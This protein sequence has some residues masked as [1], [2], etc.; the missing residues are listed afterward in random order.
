MKVSPSSQS[1]FLVSSQVQQ[2]RQQPSYQLA[3]STNYASH[4]GYSSQAG[5]QQHLY[6]QLNG[7]TQHIYDSTGDLHRMNMM[8]LITQHQTGQQ[9]A[10]DGLNRSLSSLQQQQQHARQLNHLQDLHARQPMTMKS[11]VLS[12]GFKS[13]NSNQDDAN[14]AGQLLTLD[15]QAALK[16]QQQFLCHQQQQQQQ[17]EADGPLVAF[18]SNS[19]PPTTFGPSNSSMALQQQQQQL[20]LSSAAQQQ[21]QQHQHHTERQLFNQQ[22]QHFYQDS[23]NSN[24]INCVGALDATSGQS[25]PAP[26]H[27][28]HQYYALHDNM[29]NRQQPQ[30]NY[31]EALKAAMMQQQRQDELDRLGAMEPQ[32]H[33]R[34]SISK[35]QQQR[36]HQ[37]NIY[38]V[39]QYNLD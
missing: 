31:T 35:Q 36:H 19:Q 39:A 21:Q 27:Q 23:G 29:A 33:F 11:M 9:Q 18:S 4:Y 3:N 12:P 10:F 37:A 16:Q 34:R 17:G 28:Q 20:H 7:P 32:P 26:N 13:N 14:E 8:Q 1:L 6:Q 25:D 24:A 15:A 30:S 2:Q 38:D 5:Q 22:Q